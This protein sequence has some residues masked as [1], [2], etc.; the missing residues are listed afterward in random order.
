MGGWGAAHLAFKYPDRFCAVTLVSALL[1]T[2]DHFPQRQR[3]FNES[4]SAYYAEDPITRAH[5]DADK[6]K[7]ALKIRL[8][9]GGNDNHY[10]GLDFARNFDKRLTQW[11]I[12]HTLT[13]APRVDHNDGDLYQTLGPSAFTF[14][15]QIFPI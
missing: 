14:Y 1:Y 15:K 13:I 10:R 11:N 7:D 2:Y 3:I 5:R 6:L 9:A 8:L 4:E 12:P